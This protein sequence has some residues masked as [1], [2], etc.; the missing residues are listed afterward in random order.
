M[1]E[2]LDDLLLFHM[3]DQCVLEIKRELR[4]PIRERDYPMVVDE[5]G[6]QMDDDFMDLVD[7][8]AVRIIESGA[9][10]ASEGIPFPI[11]SDQDVLL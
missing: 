3:A 1:L 8:H 2:I 11:I 10:T 5:R 7:E 4:R 9:D 6:V